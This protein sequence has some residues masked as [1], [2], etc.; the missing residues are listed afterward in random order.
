M[1]NDRGVIQIPEICHPERVHNSVRRQ[2]SG[3]YSQGSGGCWGVCTVDGG[4]GGNQVGTPKRNTSG[5]CNLAKEVEPIWWSKHEHGIF[6]TIFQSGR[7][8]DFSPASH[9]R[10]KRSLTLWS[11]CISPKVRSSACRN[12]RYNLSHAESDKH[13]YKIQSELAGTMPL[14][15]RTEKA[16]NDPSDGHD[17]WPASGEAIFEQTKVQDQLQRTAYNK[18]RRTYVVMPV[19]TLYQFRVSVFSLS[20]ALS[21]KKIRASDPSGDESS[22]NR[23][24][25]QWPGNIRSISFSPQKEKAMDRLHEARQTKVS[26]P[27]SADK[28][29]IEKSS[30]LTMIE[31][32]TPKLCKR[33]QFR[34]S[35]CL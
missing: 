2:Q 14:D 26:R 34:L 21:E 10:E 30:P 17:A 11:Q 31:N 9:P 27:L 7:E 28:R 12:G 5:N 13:R 22:D 23:D 35:S 15:V 3:I 32:E 16:N 6:R 19:I 8:G 4:Q 1:E 25:Q 18:R 24:W 33:D 29:Y 20:H